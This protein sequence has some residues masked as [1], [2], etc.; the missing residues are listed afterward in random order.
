MPVLLIG[1]FLSLSFL[2][3]AAA[4]V[5]YLQGVDNQEL[6]E[7]SS[8]FTVSLGDSMSMVPQANHKCR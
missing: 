6:T 2:E 3:S 7:F 5:C 8:G 1:C 4:H